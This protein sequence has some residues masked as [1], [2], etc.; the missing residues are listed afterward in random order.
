[1]CSNRASKPPVLVLWQEIL[2]QKLPDD[3][4]V[5]QKDSTIKNLRTA[6]EASA[7]PIS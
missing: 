4:L 3:D 5:D 2:S 1:M 6:E 7:E